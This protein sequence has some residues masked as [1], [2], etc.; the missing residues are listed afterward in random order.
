MGRRNLRPI[1]GLVAGCGGSALDVR[2]GW[3][4]TVERGLRGQCHSASGPAIRP[5]FSGAGPAA[6]KPPR[7]ARADGSTNLLTFLKN[8]SGSQDL[9]F[10]GRA[11]TSDVRPW[12]PG[13]IWRP[14][15]ACVGHPA[16]AGD[17]V[18]RP[19]SDWPEFLGR[20]RNRGYAPSIETSATDHRRRLAAAAVAMQKVEGS[21]PIIRSQNPRKIG[22]FCLSDR[23]RVSQMSP[24]RCVD[25]AFLASGGSSRAR[26]P[27][28]PAARL[29]QSRPGSA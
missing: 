22:G 25:R 17:Q 4:R 7:G 23:K 19:R 1:L 3:G 13:F 2:R 24:K 12:R 14:R 18:R 8:P 20:I 5:G 9:A 26:G 6:V 29:A 27:R 28:A 10:E 21:S 16:D 15:A 11:S